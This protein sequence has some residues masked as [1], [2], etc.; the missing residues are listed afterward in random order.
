MAVK[1]YRVGKE[2]TQSNGMKAK[3][4][5][6]DHS[7]DMTVE[8]ENALIKQHVSYYN[9]I[10]GWVTHNNNNVYKPSDRLLKKRVGESLV[11]HNNL[12][13]TIV[14]YR[15]VNDIDV[16]FE[17]G[18]LIEHSRF[19]HFFQGYLKHPT[20]KGLKWPHDAN[21][22]LIGRTIRTLGNHYRII[23]VYRID[24]VDII[25]DS[26]TIFYKKSYTGIRYGSLIEPYR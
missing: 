6:Y 14:E 21:K 18:V 1:N 16:L 15:S 23:D 10:N 22:K 25:D 26:G 17:D 5:E 24:Y 11:N 8:F 13:M 7:S 4:I 3:I 2:Q 19:A 12:I 9:F 20:K